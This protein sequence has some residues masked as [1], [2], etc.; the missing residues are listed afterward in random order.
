MTT[1]GDVDRLSRANQRIVAMA[2]ADLAG[3]FMGMDLSRPDV[4]RDALLEFVPIIVREY[5]ELAASVAAEW[6]EELRAQHPGLPAYGVTLG[7]IAAQEAVVG[8]VRYASGSLFVAEQG[9][10]LATLL[11][12]IQRHIHYSSRETIRRNAARDPGRPRY[13]RVPTGAKT[14]AWCN[15]LAS[16]G[17]VYHSE[18]SASVGASGDDFH[19]DCDCEVVVEFDRDQHHIDGYD[20]DAMYER[21]LAARRAVGG[22]NPSMKAIVAKMRR[23]FPDDYTDGVG[24]D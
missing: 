18:A 12:S 11:G 14:C 9:N 4:V 19:D 20:P 23:M 16:R 7:G 1:R 5:G 13:A 21:Y 22:V 6:Y 24:E 17:F 2:R 10:A 3:F 8:S 15:M